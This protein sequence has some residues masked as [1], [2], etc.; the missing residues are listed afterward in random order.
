MSTLEQRLD[1]AMPARRRA[2]V[3][4]WF[5][6][7]TPEDKAT[8]LARVLD[9]HYTDESFVRFLAGEGVP[10]GKQ[11]VAKWRRSLGRDR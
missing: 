9:L 5:D 3:Y 6:S 7:L 1:D 4:V 10:T 8:I 2:G 11:T